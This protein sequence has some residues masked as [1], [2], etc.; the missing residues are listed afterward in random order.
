[1]RLLVSTAGF[2]LPLP[3]AVKA[4]QLVRLSCRMV[5]HGGGQFEVAEHLVGQFDAGPAD[6]AGGLIHGSP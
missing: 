6:R 2:E 5:R 1:M 3:I 4:Q